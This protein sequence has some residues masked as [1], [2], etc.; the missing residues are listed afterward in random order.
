MTEVRVTARAGEGGRC[1]YCHDA[2]ETGAV[3]RCPACDVGIHA[4]CRGGLKRCPT[5]G[6][7]GFDVLPVL[8]P[9]PQVIRRGTTIVTPPPLREPTRVVARTGRVPPLPR[10]AGPTS[11]LGGL[12][13]LVAV[14]LG[15]LALT[16]GALFLADRL[17]AWFWVTLGTVVVCVALVRGPLEPPGGPASRRR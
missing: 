4:D 15:F 7:A 13:R 8:P 10:P 5:V 11:T 6:C 3:L 14:G 9:A 12:V 16:A 2:L 17:G 1:A